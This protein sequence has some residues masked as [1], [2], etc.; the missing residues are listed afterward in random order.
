MPFSWDQLKKQVVQDKIDRAIIMAKNGTNPDFKILHP[1]WV[2]DAQSKNFTDL[3][4]K[5]TK[6][7]EKRQEKAILRR[8]KNAPR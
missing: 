2:R 7:I 4:I 8:Q 5:I 6:D 1:D 3:R